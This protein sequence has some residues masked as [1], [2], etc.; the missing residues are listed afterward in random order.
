MKIHWGT[1]NSMN[2]ISLK[3]N[4]I[5]AWCICIFMNKCHQK[6]TKRNNDRNWNKFKTHRTY[7][8]DCKIKNDFFQ[9]IDF[10]VVD[11]ATVIPIHTTEIKISKNWRKSFDQLVAV[12]TWKVQRIRDR[13][14]S[15]LFVL[16]FHKRVCKRLTM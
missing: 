11:S 8:N 5:F 10:N 13:F 4:F 12:W 1:L 16:K 6:L 15:A 14:V 7:L 9:Q 2:L 3:E